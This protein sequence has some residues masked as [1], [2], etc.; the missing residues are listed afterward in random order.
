VTGLRLEVSNGDDA[1]LELD[2]VETRTTVPDLYLAAEAG[3]YDLLLGYPD[4]RAPVYELERVRSAILAVPAAE[5]GALDL[6]PNPDFN[7]SSRIAGSAATQKI[8][9]W[10][11]LAAAVVVLVA[12]TLRAARQEGAS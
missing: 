9:L 11:A 5:I 4:D 7:A 1:P 6:E 8:I 2:D 12:L 10:A 3:D